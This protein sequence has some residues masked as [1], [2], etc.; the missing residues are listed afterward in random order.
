MRAYDSGASH[1]GA[2]VVVWHAGSPHTGEPLEPLVR[3]A[4]ARGI[5]LV[6]FARPG[7][8]GSTP[9][10]G[11]DV[12]SVAHDVAALADAL[13]LDRFAVAGYSGGGPHALACAALLP[14]RVTAAAVLASPSP[15]GADDGWF[16]GMHEPGAL[17]AAAV[18]RDERL[19][20]AETDEFDPAQFTDRD[21]AVLGGEWGAVGRDAGRAE[22][23]GPGGLVDDDV[24]FTRAWGFELA[25]VH[26]PVLL[27]QGE[28]DRVIPRAHAVRLVAGL[29]GARLWMRLDDGHVAVLDVV[30]EVLDWLA[31]RSGGMPAA[32]AAPGRDSGRLPDTPGER[33][34]RHGVSPKSS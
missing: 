4:R 31:E 12:A 24:A 3:A 2:P 34:P 6:T 7:Y 21:F 11:R 23:A 32:D 29:P 13:D 22:S 14:D 19:R 20:F 27:V 28:L 16:A 10:P 5:R 18:S 1:P 8:G 30:P 15:Y 17:R 9:R 33:M 25:D 26:V